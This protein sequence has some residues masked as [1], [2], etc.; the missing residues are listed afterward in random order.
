MKRHAS[1]SPND[2]DTIIVVSVAVIGACQTNGVLVMIDHPA[3]DVLTAMSEDAKKGPLAR[4]LLIARII[5]ISAAVAGAVPTATN[6]YHS[7]KHDIPYSQVSHRLSQYDL[8]V[9]NFECKIDYKAISTA[10]GTKVDVGACPKSG[11]IA[12]KLTASN[13]K[14]AYEWIAA[15]NLQKSSMAAASALL[16][17][18]VSPAVAEELPKTAVEAAASAPARNI[19]LSQSS[20]QVV[21]QAMPTKSQIVRIINEG[22]KCYRETLSPFAGKVDKREEVPCNTACPA[23]A[24]S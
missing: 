24:K 22:G 20:I 7:W 8:W 12:I 16:S 4:P 13:G 9:K 5:A 14:A 1:Q 3:K 6:F 10:Q 17:L 11:D 2:H 23:P 19:Q 18:F 15:E 21:C